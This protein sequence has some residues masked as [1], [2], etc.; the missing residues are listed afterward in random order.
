MVELECRQPIIYTLPHL[1]WHPKGI[2]EKERFWLKERW[3]TVR[4]YEG[5]PGHDEPH[6][7]RVSMN[8]GPKC[9]RKHPDCVDLCQLSKSALVQELGKIEC[10]FRI[11]RC[12]LSTAGSSKYILPVAE[13]ITVI[14]V[15][16]YIY[17]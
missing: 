1:T 10:V 5:I 2:H 15:K 12:C 11:M 6:I 8:A 14:P 16:P 4:R 13:S 3:W 9:V 17:I 7:L